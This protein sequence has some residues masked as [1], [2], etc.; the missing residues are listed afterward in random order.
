VLELYRE[1]QDIAEKRE[2]LQFLVMMD[3]DAVW[4]EIDQALDE[5]P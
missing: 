3:S 5:R 4:D 2:L 1:T